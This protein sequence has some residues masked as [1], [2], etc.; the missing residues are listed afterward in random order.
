ME[1]MKPTLTPGFRAIRE[2]LPGVGTL[3]RY[4]S[5]Y[6]QYSSRYDK[7]KEGVVLNAFQPALSNGATMDIGVYTIYPM[8]VLFGRPKSTTIG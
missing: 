4:F 3:R 5:C 8:V 7:L 2:Q 1:A 6:C